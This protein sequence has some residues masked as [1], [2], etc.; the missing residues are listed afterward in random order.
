MRLLTAED[1]ARTLEPRA[2]VDALREGFKAGATVPLRHHHPLPGEDNAKGMLLLMPAWRE[3]A[4]LGVKIATVFTENPKRGLSSVMGVYYLCDGDTG[5]PLAVMDAT[6]LTRR[7]TAAASALGADYLA[8]PDARTLLV[9]GT[10]ALAPHFIAAHRAV[11]DYERVLVYGRNRETADEL[12]KEV[13]GVELV[14]D[15]RAGVDAADV[16][17]C[18]TTSHDPVVP[19]AW[20]KPGQHLDMAGGF[21]PRM[22]ET[23]DDGVTR[24]SVFIDSDGALKEAGDIVQP[25]TAGVLK[26][27]DIKGDLFQLTRG[28]RPGRRSA[29][30]ITLFK[31]VGN[32]IEDLIGAALAYESSGA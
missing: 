10:G 31:S 25:M 1:V 13:H 7:R 20:L 12:R 9:V 22:R 6:E 3:G 14:E 29:D 23:D 28:E 19:G 11:R 5:T 26:P 24:A 32:A 30:E 4:Y 27:D 17:S 18:V 8:R 16:I 21:T 15:L 2:L